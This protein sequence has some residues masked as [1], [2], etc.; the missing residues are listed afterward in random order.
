MDP[1]PDPQARFLT[2]DAPLTDAKLL[3]II[4]RNFIDWVYRTSK[5]I[6]RTNQAL[7]LFATP[8]IYHAEFMKTCA[9]LL[10]KP[11]PLE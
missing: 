1:D 9:T 8:D 11:E 6:V 2:L 10:V 5:I 3:N 7:G 4:Q